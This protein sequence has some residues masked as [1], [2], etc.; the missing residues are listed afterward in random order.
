MEKLE[1]KCCSVDSYTLHEL[2]CYHIRENAVDSVIDTFN[3]FKDNNFEYFNW[4]VLNAML[5]LSACELS[6]YKRLIPFLVSNQELDRALVKLTPEFV[7]SGKAEVLPHIFEAINLKIDTHVRYMF[8]EMVRQNR[9]AA[10]YSYVWFQLE[11]MNFYIRTNLAAYKPVLKSQSSALILE[12]L[13]QLHSDP[14]ETLNE[15]CF[16][17]LMK[18]AAEENTG[19]MSDVINLMC[20]TYSVRPRLG[21]ITSIIIPLLRE[22]GLTYVQIVSWLRRT[23]IRLVDGIAACIQCTLSENDMKTACLIIT[24][25]KISVYL[26]DE[27]IT[28]PLLN[29]YLAT[30]D[31]DGFVR[32]L[33]LI[34]DSIT[35]TNLYHLKRMSTQPTESDAIAE[36]QEFSAQMIRKTILAQRTNTPENLRL[37]Q[38]LLRNGFS[39]SSEKSRYLRKLL[40]VA[41]DSDIDRALK[42]LCAKR[43][44]HLQAMTEIV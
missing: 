44:D 18:L 37:L 16:K 35:V 25:T 1:A 4:R 33:R 13:Q 21:F 7:R 2:L 32:L 20:T 10:E 38:T 14:K 27:T 12:I 8:T 22:K 41:E 36:Q 5:K 29:A 28:I 23:K 15:N 17:Q 26:A 31:V 39:I 34:V 40:N 42:E 30:R 3:Q 6:D 19:K 11:R 43:S 9:A 24:T